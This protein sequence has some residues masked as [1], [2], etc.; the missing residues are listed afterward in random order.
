MTVISGV[1]LAAVLVAL[2]L[3]RPVV[4][5]SLGPVV[6][7]ERRDTAVAEVAEIDLGVRLDDG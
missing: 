2:R 6:I 5:R 3:F 4:L 1:L 7:D